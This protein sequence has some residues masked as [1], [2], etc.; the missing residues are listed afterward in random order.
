MT[1]NG[2]TD[3]EQQ[4]I[5]ALLAAEPRPTMPPEV[6]L[7]ILDA[8]AA[9]P[10]LSPTE[11]PARRSFRW[12]PAAVAAA[13]VLL[14]GVVIVPQL[15]RSAPAETVAAPDPAPTAALAVSPT[16]CNG[17]T[18]AYETGTRYQQ[19]NLPQQARSLMP[20]AVQ[21]R[22]DAGAG[23][24]PRTT[25]PS[26]A[27]DCIVKITRQSRVLLLDQGFYDDQPA[28]LAVVAP[29]QRALVVDCD[30]RPA[31]VL[32]SVSLE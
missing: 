19:A 7:Q 2:A 8:L 10:A 15:Q 14:A 3:A 12:W 24:A 29:P 22:E 21:C 5:R 31:Q 26:Q 18:A 32:Q 17:D 27:L 4:Q 11:A 28:V 20:A 9:E 23:S 6:R 16:G 1:D 25:A 30:R 13:V